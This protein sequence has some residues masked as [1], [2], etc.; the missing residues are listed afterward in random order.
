MYK[1]CKVFKVAPSLEW[2]ASASGAA[3][4][5][6]IPQT[7]EIQLE[8]KM[9]QKYIFGGLAFNPKVFLQIG[10]LAWCFLEK[11][12]RKRGPVQ[13]KTSNGAGSRGEWIMQIEHKLGKLISPPS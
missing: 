10:F 12:Q 8:I 13:S 4:C 11:M 3:C 9:Q 7:R 5:R 1:F 2:L 6:H